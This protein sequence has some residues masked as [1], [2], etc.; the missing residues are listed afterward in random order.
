MS[1]TL[2][3]VAM[4]GTML[5][6]WMTSDAMRPNMLLLFPDQWRWDWDGLSNETMIP[7]ILPTIVGLARN[8]TRFNAYVPAPVCAPSRSCL[9][10]GR[11]YDRA[12]VPSNFQ[13][14]YPINQTTFYKLLRDQYGYH[15][16]TVGKDDLTKASQLGTRTGG[17]DW[18]GLYHQSE[19]G[20]SDGLRSSGKDDVV[21]TKTPHEMYGHFL[22]LH[23]VELSNGTTSSA[24]DTHRLCMKHNNACD[25]AKAFP[26]AYYEDNWVA[27]S[28]LTLLKRRPKD[29]PWFLQVN[30]P[31]PHPPFLVTST[32]T[33]ATSGR[34]FPKAAD[35]P[36]AKEETCY[37]D[38]RPQ[39]DDRCSYAA[40]I[41][42]LDRLFRTILDEV[43][44]E[45]TVV[46]MASDHGEMLGDHGDTG[47]TMP[48][49]GSSKV[50]LACMGPNIAR[51][52]IVTRPVG[53]I[54]LAA[55]FLEIASLSISRVSEATSPYTW[56]D[57]MSLR[58]LMMAEESTAHPTYSRRVVSSGL[59]NWR[60]VVEN[61]TN[62]KFICCNGTCPGVPQ[63]APGVNENGFQSIL[64]NTRDDPFD[65]RPLINRSEDEARLRKF[66][67]RSFGCR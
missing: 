24:W 37:D 26:D 22:S 48:W 45:R 64:Y 67:P 5:T 56:E 65:M 59:D 32:M 20:F 53:T 19:L 18:R 11:A 40:E 52:R 3:R 36:N 44:T 33:K 58:S 41:Q 43:D 34:T 1:K 15:T 23:E 55:T 28:A 63:N 46:C 60:M 27:E 14:D 8:G 12:G 13:N 50:P 30:F 35:N 7:L 16:M 31:G 47:K 4:V 49:Q 9:A 25:D 10:S 17:G 21:D 6:L 29:K 42:N 51:G 57:S 38:G 39:N 62:L 54:D 2:I 66:L 61:A